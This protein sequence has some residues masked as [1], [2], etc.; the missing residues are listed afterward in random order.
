MGRKNSVRTIRATT[1]AGR[2]AECAGD[3]NRLQLLSGLVEEAA[4]ANHGVKPQERQRGRRNLK[5]DTA[6]PQVTLKSVRQRLPR[7]ANRRQGVANTSRLMGELGYDARTGPCG[8]T[9][10]PGR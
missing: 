2:V 10:V 7:D 5:I 4:H 3:A 1:N 6:L 9:H 8:R